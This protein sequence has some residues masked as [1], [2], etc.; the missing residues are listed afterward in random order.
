MAMEDVKLYVN[1]RQVAVKAY[2]CGQCLRNIRLERDRQWRERLQ[3]EAEKQPVG[4]RKRKVVEDQFLFDE[5]S[6][7]PLDEEGRLRAST[8]EYREGRKVRKFMRDHDPS[9][10]TEEEFWETCDGEDPDYAGSPE[11]VK[12]EL[13]YVGPPGDEAKHAS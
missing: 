8:V 13:K 1:G 6:G 5:Y 9:V 2:L 7:S 4:S 3:E 12:M 10:Q 11:V